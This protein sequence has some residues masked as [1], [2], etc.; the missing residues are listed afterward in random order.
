[1]LLILRITPFIKQSFYLKMR[2]RKCA[3]DWSFNLQQSL[4]FNV[5]GFQ[6]SQFQNTFMAELSVFSCFIFFLC[7]LQDGSCHACPVWTIIVAVTSSIHGT[8]D[9]ISELLKSLL[10]KLLCRS[11]LIW[12]IC[13]SKIGLYRSKVC[14]FLSAL[15]GNECCLL[16]LFIFFIINLVGT[17]RRPY[18]VNLTCD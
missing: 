17:V 14:L 12:C 3:V 8:G 16:L 4:W 9:E 1:M 5:R 18:K 2:Y 11:S 15:N 10:F 6:R 7:E 13:K